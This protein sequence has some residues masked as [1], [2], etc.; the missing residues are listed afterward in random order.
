MFDYA[1]S[2][3]HYLLYI[4]DHLRNELVENPTPEFNLVDHVAERSKK[5]ALL[6]YEHPV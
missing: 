1:R 6:R 5:E 3:T 2:D 4:Y